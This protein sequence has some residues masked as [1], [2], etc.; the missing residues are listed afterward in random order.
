MKGK[1]L[2]TGAAGFAGSHLVEYLLAETDCKIS[3]QVRSPD[4]ARAAL[5]P[6]GPRLGLASV[7]LTD[8]AAVQQLVTAAAPDY[9]FLLA[10]QPATA[11][12]WEIPEETFRANVLAQMSILEALASSGQRPRVLV[13]GSADAYGVVYPDELPVGEEQPFR[14]TNPYGVSKVAQELI[15]YAYHITRGLPVIRARPF[16]HIGPRQGPDFVAAAIARQLALIAAG[17]SEPVLRLGNTSPRRDFTDVR[18]IVRAYALLLER[19]TPGDVYNVGS[20]VARAVDELVAAFLAIAGVE[21]RVE[22]DPELARPVDV[23]ELRCDSSKLRRATGW[24]PRVPFEET[25]R[26]VYL[27]W[28]RRVAHRPG[29]A[30]S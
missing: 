14:P 10:G 17:R 5:P 19:G 16:N 3:G 30:P 8:R 20:G 29:A 24:A 7:E 21:A 18:D 9:V 15:G 2:V 4:R 1:V 26:D 12:S 28:R 25:I 23:P 6:P 11:R 13:V 27:D 22:S